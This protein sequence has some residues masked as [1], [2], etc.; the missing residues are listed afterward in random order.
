M[1]LMKQVYQ[2]KKPMSLNAQPLTQVA[3]GVLAPPAWIGRFGTRPVLAT[4][5]VWRE[6]RRTRRHL[7]TLD[8]RAL[9]DVGLTRAQQR[10]ECTKSFWQL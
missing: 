3:F 2:R 5:L 1:L 10:S 7:S 4:F 8:D 6:R 9:A